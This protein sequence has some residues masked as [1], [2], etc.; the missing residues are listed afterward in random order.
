MNDWNIQSRAHACQACGKGFCD[1]Q[2][3]H[4]VLFDLKQEIHRQDLCQVC[5][6][7]EQGE[8]AR[9][10][11]GFISQWQGTFAV[12]PPAPPEAIRKENA[13]TL[14]R[15]ILNLDAPNGGNEVVVSSAAAST[16]TSTSTSVSVPASASAS[17]S[18]YIAAAYILAAKLERQRIL[19]V[20]E[21]FQREGR[22]FFVYEHARTAEIFTI[23]DPELQLNQLDQVQ[24]EVAALLDHGLHAAPPVSAETPPSGEINPG[25]EELLE[26]EQDG[27][28]LATPAGASA[29][30]PVV[31]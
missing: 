24:R 22:R 8:G 2:I 10:R 30:Q 23:A 14:L 16:S 18:S 9:D 4:T 29:P 20:K 28:L 12:P 27:G 21:Q 17:S 3:Y 26:G 15:K 11:K 19:K 13:E 25:P 7:Q 31:Q 6:E 1:Q 5:W